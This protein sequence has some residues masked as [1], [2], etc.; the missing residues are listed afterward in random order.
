QPNN[1]TLPRLA[2]GVAAL[3]CGAKLLIHLL[4][5]HQYGYFRDE[6]YFLDCGRHL[7]WGYAD[8]AP[9]AAFFAKVGLMLGG[10]LREIRFSVAVAGSILVLLAILLARA[11]GGGKFAQFLSGFCA[12]AATAYLIEDG[13]LSMNAFEPLAWMACILVLLR[14]VRTGNSRLWLW[15]GLFAGLGL[16]NKHSTLFFGV[17][18][19]CGLLLTPLRREFLKP[20]IWLGG[21]VAL[22]VFL[23]NLIWEYQHNFAT[24]ELLRNVQKMHKNVVLGP[25]AYFGHQLI[26][27]NPFEFLVWGAGLVWLFSPAGRR[28]RVLAFTY[29]ALFVLFLLF[30]GKDYYL[31]PIYP[32]LMAAGAVAWEQWSAKRTWMRPALVTVI[33]FTSAILAPIALPLFTPDHLL[34]YEQ[35]LHIQPPK[36]EVNHNGPLPQY[37]GDQFGWEERSEEHTSELQS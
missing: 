2:Y 22:L 29:V 19:V 37:F 17:A 8:M 26:S 31:F 15:F 20:W 21:L 27:L 13:F 3:L 30:K 25:M 28:F 12:L 23:P 35:R 34:V 18:I 32:M 7:A 1:P 6:L 16:E 4:T 33:L 11:L 10:S 9:I 14:I 36:S 24:L 5:N